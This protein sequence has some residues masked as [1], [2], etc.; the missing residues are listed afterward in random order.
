M[1]ESWRCLHD[2]KQHTR[3]G[4]TPDG[5]AHQ[6][7]E[8]TRRN[9]ARDRK[10][11]QTGEH[12]KRNIARDSAKMLVYGFLAIW[13]VHVCLVVS[14]T[15]VN[16]VTKVDSANV[17]N[18]AEIEDALKKARE[19][20]LLRSN[21]N[22]IDRSYGN[23]SRARCPLSFHHGVR[24]YTGDT[25]ARS[26]SKTALLAMR[27]LME[28]GGYSSNDFQQEKAK[29]MFRRYNELSCDLPQPGECDFESKYR[30]AD[31]SCNNVENPDWGMTGAM[32][33][34]VLANDYDD[35]LG[36]PRT[37]GFRKRAL[38]NPRK[39]SNVVHKNPTFRENRSNRLT[40]HVMG[41]GQFLDH[42]IAITPEEEDVPDCC[43]GSARDDTESCF[44]IIIQESS[45]ETSPIFV[46][47]YCMEVKRSAPV[48][49][50]DA[51]SEGR[52]VRQQ[53]NGLTS[54]IDASNVYGSTV[55]RQKELRENGNGYRLATSTFNINSLK[56]QRILN[57]PDDGCILTDPTQHCSLAGDIRVNEIPTLT[58]YHF[59]F[60]KEHNRI[61]E[62]IK[63]YYDDDETI[64]QGTRRILIAIMQKIVYDEFLP[65]FFS[66]EGLRTYRLKSTADY[67]YEPYTNPTL[68][69]A[70]GIAYR[71][72]HSWVPQQVQLLDRNFR[73]INRE[74]FTRNTED[75]FLN[76]DLTYEWN[77]FPRLAFFMSGRRSPET[78][79]VLEEAIRSL[80]FFNANTNTA[81]DLAALN[82]QRG[83]DHGLPS[84]NE[85]RRW[86]GLSLLNSEWHNSGLVDHTV[87]MQ[88]LLKDAGYQSPLDIDL[89]VGGMTE[90]PL[91]DGN[92]GP[93]FECIIGRHFKN[94][95]FGDRFWYQ[96][97]DAG[98]TSEQI[99]AIQ[100]YSLAKVLCNNYNYKNINCP[101]A[102]VSRDPLTL[103]QHI[104]DLDLSVFGPKTGGS[105][106]HEL[107]W[108]WWGKKRSGTH[109]R[110]RTEADGDV[111]ADDLGITQ[112]NNKLAKDNV[113]TTEADNAP[114]YENNLGADDDSNADEEDYL[115]I[116]EQLER[117]I[118]ELEKA[119]EKEKY[120]Y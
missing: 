107:G 13:A 44:N 29:T 64:F 60:V 71:V 109:N 23:S 7:G 38:P 48:F 78:D 92:L 86:C 62:E 36:H 5:K 99:S 103:C 112:V 90:T 85:Y 57:G 61:A 75:V 119:K 51:T 118:H 73:Q 65:S 53:T 55:E 34:R 59:L 120:E 28:N 35:N 77:A 101:S 74:G 39:V 19:I 95:K 15:D 72:G 84:Y 97:D 69:N 22:L 8:H 49:C 25:T 115:N 47:G 91:R 30:T 2:T 68:L 26:K 52:S 58:S 54:F 21:K 11:H 42:D 6:T 67:R 32:Q 89:F 106:H 16:D 46:P 12:T 9:I 81:F 102:F 80:L 31:G 117:M 100:K 79:R 94:L 104:P 83:R 14:F 18:E 24:Q 113:V 98:F 111:S 108:W 76:P 17:P 1:E 116:G 88:R 20:N 27:I 93:T 40:L 3:R 43:E 66:P 10:A 70:F 82:I 110:I 96:N 63:A 50:P 56:F 114:A 45:I 87:T 4:S 33:Q 37:K 41:F 105:T